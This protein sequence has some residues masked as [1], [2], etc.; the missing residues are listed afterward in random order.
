MLKLDPVADLAPENALKV[1]I[2]PDA[3]HEASQP[4][5]KLGA[6]NDLA[7]FLKRLAVSQE[8]TITGAKSDAVA[9]LAQLADDPA[10]LRVVKQ[11][12]LVERGLELAE[13][14]ACPLCDGPWEM[15]LLATHL[16]E[17]IAKADA[18]ST[19]LKQLALA[20]DPLAAHLRAMALDAGKVAEWC[21]KANPPIDATSL[22]SHAKALDGD[23][24]T[25]DKVVRDPATI[26]PALQ[27]LGR[28]GASPAVELLQ[29]ADRLA[30]YIETLSDPSK[31]EEAKEFLIVAQEKYDQCRGTQQTLNIAAQQ[32]ET[33][34]AVFSQ[35][36]T[37][38]TAMLEGIYDK[39]QKD[40]TEYYSFINRDDEANFEGKLSA[41]L[42]K[43]AFDV[44][45]Y[46]RGR[47]PPGAY[48]SEG[49]QDGMGLCLYLALVKHTL[50]D[51][52]TLAVLD[53][54]LMSVDAGHRRE[55]CAL[56]KQK[57]PN[58]QFVLTTHDGVW[59]KF[60][61]SEKLVQSTLSFGGWTVDSGPQVW[62][63]GHVWT[64]I[65][66][67]LANDNVFLAA[68]TLR[69][70]L[71]FTSTILADNLRARIEYHGNGQ[72]DLGDLWPGVLAAWKARL[73]EAR[74]SASSWGK[75][76]QDAEALQIE[77]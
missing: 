59:L 55:V 66:K 46:G 30:A 54:V 11:R 1:G 16:Q 36:G 67:H 39:V 44:D 57:F 62:N 21:E 8:I 12:A 68:G 34:S 25:L 77:S 76:I 28:L 52:F 24:D 38:S 75:N 2:N 53:D 35:Y 19:A 58:T 42:G 60:M 33:A 37:V 29:P 3:E 49:H 27:A 63:E 6:K 70:Y 50:G 64:Q 47:F 4:F 5:S 20:I 10:L 18:A 72:Y 51:E 13:G 32:A 43:L 56:L 22:R 74:D 48:H 40:F 7:S 65:Q 14:D 45:F 26:A 73:K 17:K 71:E 9:A 69:R 23:R 41:S 61:Q 31:E 15:A